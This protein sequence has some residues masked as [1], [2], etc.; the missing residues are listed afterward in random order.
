MCLT[1]LVPGIAILV[2]FGLFDANI[3]VNIFSVM[4][5]RSQRF[6]SITSTFFFWG[7]GVNMSF[8]MSQHSNP[9]GART[10]PLVPKSS[11]PG[12]RE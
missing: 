3:P 4:S 8:S 2:W 6:L 10:R 9:T 1:N 7:G 12:H 11:P 5:G